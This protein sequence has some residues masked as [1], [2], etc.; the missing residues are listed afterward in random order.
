[1]KKKMKDLHIVL[2]S[3]IDMKN[4]IIVDNSA[5]GIMQ[6][7]NMVPITDFHGSCA[8]RE[9]VKLAGYLVELSK[10]RGVRERIKLD[11]MATCSIIAPNH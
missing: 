11:F 4:V 3:D 7:E 8:D 1:M 6:H 5:I 9:L 10:E 2:N